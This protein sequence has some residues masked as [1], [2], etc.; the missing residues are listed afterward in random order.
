MPY[1]IDGCNLLGELGWLGEYGKDRDLIEQVLF[2][3]KKKWNKKLI[4]F[5]DNADFNSYEENNFV[6]NGIRVFYCQKDFKDADTA[7]LEFIK[8]N[9][10]KSGI[11]LVTSD[12]ELQAQAKED[13]CRLMKTKDFL[14]FIDISP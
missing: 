7:I 1:L 8:N 3:F 9:P 11:V 14:S 12:R 5:F 13:G 4:V 10:H 6:I 2:S